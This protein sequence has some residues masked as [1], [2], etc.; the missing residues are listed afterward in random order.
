VFPGQYVSLVNGHAL[1]ITGTWRKDNFDHQDKTIPGL[2]FCIR[3]A[4]E[5]V[6]ATALI[7]LVDQPGGVFHL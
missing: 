4:L 5:N 6:N 1:S 7:E 3:V 2:G